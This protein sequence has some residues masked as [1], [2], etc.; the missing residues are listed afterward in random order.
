MKAASDIGADFVPVD[1]CFNA[2]FGSATAG[3]DDLS[4]DVPRSASPLPGAPSWTFAR[5]HTVNT[6]AF[7]SVVG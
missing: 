6:C 7:P 2:D 5:V 1:V 4:K 3:V